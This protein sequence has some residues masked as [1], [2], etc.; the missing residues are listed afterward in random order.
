MSS[1]CYADTPVTAS[2]QKKIET[3]VERRI[4]TRKP[5][6]YLLKRIY[7]LGVPFND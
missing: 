5:A 1:V 3:L 2:Q 7:M 6:A 4:R